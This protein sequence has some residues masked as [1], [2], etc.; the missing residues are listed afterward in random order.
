MVLND[1][2]FNIQKQYHTVVKVNTNNLHFYLDKYTSIWFTEYNLR[3]WTWLS[4]EK[5]TN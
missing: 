4:V 5:K 2:G 3:I 1:T